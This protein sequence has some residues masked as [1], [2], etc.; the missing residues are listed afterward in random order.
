MLVHFT[1]SSMSGEPGSPLP[2]AVS[3]ASFDLSSDQHSLDLQNQ[4][5]LRLL[6][7][8][9]LFGGAVAITVAVLEDG[10][11]TGLFIGGVAMAVLLVAVVP[12]IMYICRPGPD[13]LKI[14]G[15]R[16][17]FLRKGRVFQKIDLQHRR[18]PIGITTYKTP[19]G[20]P[21]TWP[22]RKGKGIPR[23]PWISRGVTPGFALNPDAL[24]AVKSHLKRHGW[25]ERARIMEL[26][27]VSITTWTFSRGRH[28]G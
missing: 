24:E 21:S 16:L 13:F 12:P 11:A 5:T 22:H 7:P 6:A 27:N 26:P 19:T 28:G 23:G 15:D 20:E 3:I 1:E 17:V 14:E 2:S 25:R 9:L 8:S 18:R 4:S 10:L